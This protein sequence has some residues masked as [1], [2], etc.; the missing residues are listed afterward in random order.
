MDYGQVSTNI[1]EIQTLRAEGESWKAITSRLFAENDEASARKLS[2]YVYRELKRQS[3]PNRLAV[4]DWVRTQRRSIEKLL[5]GGEPWIY[6]GR[7]LGCPVSLS[8]SKGLK[9]VGSEYLRLTN[10][11]IPRPTGANAVR[12]T[13]GALQASDTGNDRD[14]PEGSKPEA[15][16]TPADTPAQ[17]SKQARMATQAKDEELVSSLVGPGFDDL[18]LGAKDDLVKP[19]PELDP[20]V[21]ASEMKERYLDSQKRQVEL[22]EQI[23][24]ATDE[25]TPGLEALYDTVV[26]EVGQVNDVFE[27]RFGLDWDLVESRLWLNW[28]VTE[29]RLKLLATAALEAGVFVPTDV[30]GNDVVKL[31]GY[32]RP[33]VVE[34]F[35][36]VPEPLLIR[37]NLADEERRLIADAEAEDVIQRGTPTDIRRLVEAMLVRGVLLRRSPCGKYNGVPIPDW[38]VAVA[39]WDFSSPRLLGEALPVLLRQRR[40]V[41]RPTLSQE[42]ADAMKA[43]VHRIDMLPAWK[44]NGRW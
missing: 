28:D 10:H 25:D 30:D 29:S 24:S 23:R 44:R 39:G 9:L 37:E 27:Y 36:E 22:M 31:Q 7:T 18:P 16:A 8:T 12:Q 41:L 40:T 17:A 21:S 15:I 32:D 3:D 42:Q 34:G 33:S 13:Q 5:R 35:D 6:I 4:S 26:A 2:S 1:H 11:A 43:E 19:V 14:A 20:F 38:H